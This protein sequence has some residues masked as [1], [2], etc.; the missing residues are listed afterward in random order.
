MSS[1]SEFSAFLASL[2]AGP[3]PA[4]GTDDASRRLAVGRS[5]MALLDADVYVSCRLGSNDNY[6]SPVWVNMSDADMRR[7]QEH[8]QFNDP[9]TP[10]MRA[11]GRA[12]RVADI[13]DPLAL[14]ATEFHA[15]FLSANALA[16]GMNYFPASPGPG[17][18]DLRLWRTTGRDPFSPEEVALLQAGGDLIAQLLPPGAP[19]GTACIASLTARESD[20][21]AAVA[22]GL[23]DRQ[24]CRELGMSMGTLRT[25][26]SRTFVKLEVRSR[27]GLATLLASE[28]R[29]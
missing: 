8:F 4:T 26:L 7:Y 29:H 6:T 13:V 11:A 2:S 5:L 20:V 19:V 23:T 14:R 9:L 21:A 16:E 3:S 12:A 28:G 27:T 10:K 22:R 18:L 24:A 15:D 1:M 17:T 25:H